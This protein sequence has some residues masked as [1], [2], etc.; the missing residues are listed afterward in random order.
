ML[1]LVSTVVAVFAIHFV[2]AHVNAVD[3]RDRLIGLVSFD[4][5]NPH[6]ALVTKNSSIRDEE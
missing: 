6:Q 4:N 2:F 3:K 1:G 5:S